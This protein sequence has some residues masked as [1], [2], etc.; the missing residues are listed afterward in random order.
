MLE[1]VRDVF[2]AGLVEFY[3]LEVDRRIA[4]LYLARQQY[5]DIAAANDDK[6]PRRLFLVAE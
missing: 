6:S 1:R 3:E 2:S 5:A 4:V